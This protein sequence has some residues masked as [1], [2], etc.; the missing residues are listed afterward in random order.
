MP[1]TKLTNL[2]SLSLAIIVCAIPVKSAESE[3]MKACPT[4][5]DSHECEISV[6]NPHPAC[7]ESERV[8]DTLK[9]MASLLAKGD[10][11]AYSEYLAD[12]CTTFDEKTHKLIAG[13]EAV[14]ADLK[15]RLY[16]AA[17][18]GREP[19]LTLTIEEPY[20]KVS[21]D[22]A[23]VTFKA[24]KELGGAHPDREVVHATDVFVKHGDK[25]QKLHFRGKW[26][27]VS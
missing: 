5:S 6:V 27:K 25:W 20:A 7:I 21:G 26:K 2:L 17:P 9:H 22:V 23:V 10:F 8:I 16:S 14:I 3:S 12:G 13:K 15:K 24:V 19:V 11:E 4:G 1:T 18:D